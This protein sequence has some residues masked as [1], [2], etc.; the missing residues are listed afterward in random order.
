MREKF[1]FKIPTERV[2]KSWNFSIIQSSDDAVKHIK[3][4]GTVGFRDGTLIRN[5]SDGRV[6]LI[7]HNKRLHISDPDTF[8]KYGLNRDNIIEVSDE[9]TQLHNIG[10]VLV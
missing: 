10:E 5:F 3:T 7:S 1:K 8:A 9:E 6:Y 2:V 4:A